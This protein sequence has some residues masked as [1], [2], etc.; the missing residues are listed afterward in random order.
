MLLI[1]Q[2]SVRPEARGKGIGTALMKQAEIL[3]STLDVERIVLD[4]WD[5]NSGAHAFFESRGFRKSTFR[6]WKW[7]QEK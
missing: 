2:I 6:F 3:A 5:F 7:L 1:D 4:S